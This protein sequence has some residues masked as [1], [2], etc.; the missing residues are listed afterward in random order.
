MSWRDDW[1]C[2]ARLSTAGCAIF[3]SGR[4]T[5]RRALRTGRVRPV[6]ES[7][8]IGDRRH[9]LKVKRNTR[10]CSRSQ[11]FAISSA[12]TSARAISAIAISWRWAT[13]TPRLSALVPIGSAGSRAIPWPSN[14]NTTRTRSRK[15]SAPFWGA[16][17]GVDPSAIRFQ[18][19]SNSGGMA[20]RTWRSKYGVLTVRTADTY[21][22]AR[23]QAWMDGVRAVWP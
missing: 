14:F 1:L 6:G 19:K 23:L 22:R 11:A 16:L 17:L 5:G 3:R 21:F 15:S 9:T 10:R 13:P 18:R 2:R 4:Q 7:I 8:G 20:G 12:C